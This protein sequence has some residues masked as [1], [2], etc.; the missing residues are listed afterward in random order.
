MCA[1]V[2]VYTLMCVYVFTCVFARICVECRRAGGQA[3][4]TTWGATPLQVLWLAVRLH[5]EQT[6]DFPHPPA[7]HLNLG[8]PEVFEVGG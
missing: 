4:G 8:S 6:P 7:L 2:C 1:C 5:S 3:P